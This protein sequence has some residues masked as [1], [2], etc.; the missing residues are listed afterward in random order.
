VAAGVFLSCAGLDFENERL[1]DRGGFAHKSVFYK[2]R[3]QKMQTIV[4]SVDLRWKPR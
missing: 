4:L 1:A 3:H 2:P